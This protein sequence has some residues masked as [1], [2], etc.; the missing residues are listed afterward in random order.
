[1]SIETIR[2]D[3]D[4]VGPRMD[5]IMDISEMPTDKVRAIATDDVY[6]E[7]RGTRTFLVPA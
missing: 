7:R 6:L 2:T 5:G 1:M 4:E 3:G